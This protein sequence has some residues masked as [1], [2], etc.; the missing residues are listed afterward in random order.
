MDIGLAARLGIE[1]TRLRIRQPR[2]LHVCCS[3]P[4]STVSDFGT[5][6]RS[7]TPVNAAGSN[8]QDPSSTPNI[9]GLSSK[10]PRGI[11]GHSSDLARAPPAPRARRARPFGCPRP[12]SR[13]APFSIRG[14]YL[15][16]WATSLPHSTG[17][18]PRLNLRHVV[19]GRSPQG[20][21]R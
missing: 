20:P 6:R 11:G 4:G 5:P 9:L 15:R 12:S 18:S 10:K 21:Y 19:N 17:C 7:T 1:T 13:S 8:A 2:W 3:A 16:P 14:A